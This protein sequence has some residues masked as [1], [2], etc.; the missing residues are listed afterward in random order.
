[1]MY[2]VEYTYVRSKTSANSRLKLEI[3]FH[4]IDGIKED[5]YLH[6]KKL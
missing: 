2:T 4:A 1:M 6:V 5:P 3:I